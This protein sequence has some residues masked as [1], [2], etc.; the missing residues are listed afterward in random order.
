MQTGKNVNKVWGSGGWKRW[1]PEAIQRAGFSKLSVRA[2][3]DGMT[4]A[5]SPIA[6][7]KVSHA[8]V[9]YSKQAV[10]K[11]ILDGT[12]RGLERIRS[13]SLSNPFNF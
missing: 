5:R 10:A 9:A 13:A 3:A 4:D 2:F 1:T 11:I 6:F 8:S 7:G 12:A